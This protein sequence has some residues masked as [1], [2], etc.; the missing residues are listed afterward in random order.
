M[1]GRICVKCRFAFS[2]RGEFVCRKGEFASSAVLRFH[3]GANL[4]AERANLSQVQFCVF[5][6]GRILFLLRSYI[7]T[8]FSVYHVRTGPA[9]LV[10]I[11]YRIVKN[12]QCRRARVSQSGYRAYCNGNDFA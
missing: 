6:K 4:Y 3:E 7:A 2:R 1:K 12:S 11:F 9:C 10:P 8:L 5:T